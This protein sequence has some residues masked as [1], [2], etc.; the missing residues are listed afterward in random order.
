VDKLKGTLSSF[1][2]TP[3]ICVYNVTI[4]FFVFLKFTLEAGSGN[5]ISELDSNPD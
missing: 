3:Y 5:V 1:V 4:L 2:S